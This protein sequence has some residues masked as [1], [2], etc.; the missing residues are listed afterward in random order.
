MRRA[1]IAAAVRE[2][3]ENLVHDLRG[4][5]R[6]AWDAR[7][8]CADWRV[9]DVVGHLIR[10]GDW[11][12]RPHHAVRD[13]L[14]SPYR[15]NDALSAAARRIGQSPPDELLERLESARYE[16]TIGF[17]LHPQPL[18]ALAELVVHGQDIR[19]PLGVTPSFDLEALKAVAEVSTKWYT[20]G[21]RQRRRPERFEATDAAWAMG[22][23]PPT[24]RGPLEAI[25]MVM[26]ARD[27]A[28]ADLDES[29]PS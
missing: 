4:L 3:R 9:R 21:G 12:R 28:M 26:F 15:L 24:L 8:L 7:S 2:Q 14:G 13:V 27:S 10:L 19:R 1:E 17:R 29:P 20:W 23:G 25:V 16:E 5:S 22:E 18:F 6:E 11:N